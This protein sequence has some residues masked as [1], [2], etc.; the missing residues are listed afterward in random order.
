MTTSTLGRVDPPFVADERAM[1]AAWLDYHRATL[2]LKCAGVSDEAL[3][4]RLDGHPS[5]L[6]L[7]G[8]LRHL[9]DAERGWFR[10]AIAAEDAPPLYYSEEDPDGD[11]NNVDKAD[12]AEVLATW[13]AECG[14]SREILAG[15]ESLDTTFGRRGERISV[16]WLLV[17]MIGEYARHNGHADLLRERV[18]GAKEE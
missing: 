12:V 18:D 2:E 3:R 10:R 9:A 5:S 6:S 4:Q 14:R 11:L 8:L 13:R 17:D 1:L 15:V 16:R 7:L